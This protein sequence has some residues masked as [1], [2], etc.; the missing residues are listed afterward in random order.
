M[1]IVI[2]GAKQDM[3]EQQLHDWAAEFSGTELVLASTPD[4]QVAA[5]PGANAWL[6]RISRD[7]FLAAG[8]GLRWIHA[9]GAGIE[10]MTAIPELVES[11]VVVTNT[12][13][14]HAACVAEHTFA[15]LLSLTRCVPEIV[16]NQDK[17]LYHN[18]GIAGG[19]REV[20]GATMVIVGFGNLGLAVA[21][22]ALA[23]EMRVI[24]VDMFPGAVPEGVEAVVG[25]DRLDDVL[26]EADVL[27]IAVPLTGETRGLI[28]RDRIARMRPSSYLL[29]ISRGGIVDDGAVAEALRTGQLAGAGLDVQGT[30]PLPPDDA[31]WDAPNVLISPH[32]AS[33]SRQTTDRV[34]AMTRDNVRRFVSGQPLEN[35]CDKRAGF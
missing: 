22:R 6:G 13:G 3:G 11:D 18:P 12:R 27:V 15:M 30:E 16:R 2:G 7:A 26:T 35:I 34:W 29:A 28:G 21:K 9:T 19:L 31:L 8:P 20:S 33:T 1:K 25:L 14:S 4:E 10:K 5:A 23:F 24:G 17:R 32:N